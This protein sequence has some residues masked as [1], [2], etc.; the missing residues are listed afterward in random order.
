MAPPIHIKLVNDHLGIGQN[1]LE[2]FPK[3]YLL[4]S[5]AIPALEADQKRL[6]NL[7]KK[8]LPDLYAE[9]RADMEGKVF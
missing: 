3:A 2:K 8:S 1:V 7:I 4:F 6:V 9:M 5:E